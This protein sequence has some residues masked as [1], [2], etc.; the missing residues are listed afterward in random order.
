VSAASI[1]GEQDARAGAVNEV[2][3]MAMRPVKGVPR[4]VVRPAH[5]V[6]Q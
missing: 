2:P 4:T 6:P 5:E 1:N 3:T